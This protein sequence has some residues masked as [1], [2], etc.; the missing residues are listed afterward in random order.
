MALYRGRD[1]SDLHNFR[2]EF[3]KPPKKLLPINGLGGG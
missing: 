2:S 3:E 1:R